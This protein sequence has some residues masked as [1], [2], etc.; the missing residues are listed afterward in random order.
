LHRRILYFILY[1]SYFLIS[2]SAVAAARFAA[3]ATRLVFEPCEDDVARCGVAVECV[4]ASASFSV[5]AVG[6]GCILVVV[7]KN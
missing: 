6:K 4:V 5:E 7:I 1:L 3:I 2:V